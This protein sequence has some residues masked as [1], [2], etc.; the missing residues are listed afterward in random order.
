MNAPL[1]VPAPWQR[2]ATTILNAGWRR[3]L[4]VGASDRGKSRYC[5]F[6]LGSLLGLGRRVSFVDADIGQKDV[7]PPAT[8]SLANLE[9][10]ADLAAARHDA[11]YFVG[12]TSPIAHFLP[13]V[14]GTR[15]M[16]EQ[17]TGE[18]VVVDTTG[19]VQGRGR[20]LKGFQVDSLQPDAVVCLERGDE[21][22]PIRHAARHCNILRLPPSRQAQAKSPSARR[23]ARESA[24]QEHFKDARELAFGLAEVIVQRSSLFNG[25]AVDDPRFVYAE[26]LPDRLVAVSD[27]AAPAAVEGV[28]V[29]PRHFADQLLCG[30][31]D[32]AGSCLGLGILAAIDFGRGRLVLFTPVPRRQIRIVQLGD[33]YLDREGRELHHGR[34][35]HF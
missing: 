10:P 16:A 4:V 34:L 26:R 7:G 23:R 1:H 33:L 28:Q 31:A 17:A 15:R 9:S 24:F 35:G 18:F 27:A 12:H 22:A 13:L 25:R 11:L 30:V 5:R 3:I 6:L 21:L 8:V 29:L 14:L 20:E 19:L 2:S 32:R